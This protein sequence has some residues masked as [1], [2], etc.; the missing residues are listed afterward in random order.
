[1]FRHLI[2]PN[3]KTFQD[4][5]NFPNQLNA[6][7]MNLKRKI[8]SHDPRPTKGVQTRLKDLMAEWSAHQATLE[9]IINKDVQQ[10]NDLF[11]ALKVPVLVVP[12]E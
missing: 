5:I 8:D 9:A 3:Q 11:R 6:H 4:V 2:Q 10:Y 7:F 12:K 1:M